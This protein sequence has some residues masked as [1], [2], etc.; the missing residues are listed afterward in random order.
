MKDSTTTQKTIQKDE[1]SDAS[2]PSGNTGLRLSARYDAL[3]PVS[4][5]GG[6]LGM[7]AGTLPAAVWVLLFGA[8]FEPTYVFLPLLIYLGIKTFK[9]SMDKLGF[10]V[11][12]ILSVIGYYLTVLS[13]HAALDV[14][15]FKMLFTSL[16]QV[17][18][19]LIGASGVFA[20][21]LFS[22]SYVC[23]ALFTIIGVM[24]VYELMRQKTNQDMQASTPDLSP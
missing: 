10:V 15:K 22:S 16:P 6:T 24:L 9:G 4:V 13:C 3:L 21:P 1:P 17:T 18:A 23:T 11:V 12:C 7:L 2:V 20:G 5:V 14:V 19:K 8:S